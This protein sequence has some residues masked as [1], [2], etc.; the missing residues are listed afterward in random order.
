M[1]YFG[2]I[3]VALSL[4]I[5]LVF[6]SQSMAQQNGSN[7]QPSFANGS[8]LSSENGTIRAALKLSDKPYDEYVVGVFFDN[9]I[10]TNDAMVKKNPIV[11]GGITFVRCNTESGI[12][13]KGDL[14][15]TSSEPGVAMKAIDSG[16][17]VG[18]ALEDA[19]EDGLVKTRLMI[20]YVR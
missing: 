17:V 13:K 7:L 18:I 4:I 14:I 20:Q 19:G 11:S 10:V 6:Y 12:I 16:I 3:K 5:S 8:I 9:S 2:F 1:K 15:T